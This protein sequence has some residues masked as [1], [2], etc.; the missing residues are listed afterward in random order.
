MKEYV[1]DPDEFSD[2][3]EGRVHWALMKE[4][5]YISKMDGTGRIDSGDLSL[6]LSITAKAK[7]ANHII[8]MKVGC[9]SIN[10]YADNFQ[11]RMNQIREAA[12]GDYPKATEGAFE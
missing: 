10:K 12:K 3:S 6:Y 5:I 11:E 9:G 7:G 4:P 1:L 2:L 8:A